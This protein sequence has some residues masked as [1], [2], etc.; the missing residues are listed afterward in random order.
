MLYGSRIMKNEM[1]V[2]LHGTSYLGLSAGYSASNLTVNNL[3]L[4]Y[5]LK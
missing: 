2:S 1:N 5:D 4:F 3:N